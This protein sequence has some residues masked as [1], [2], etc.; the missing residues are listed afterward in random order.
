MSTSRNWRLTLLQPILPK[1]KYYQAIGTVVNAALARLLADMLAIPDI[2]K[3]E[4]H[5]LSELCH[6]LNASEG[7]FVEDPAQV[8]AM[9]LSLSSIVDVECDSLRLSSHIF[10]HGSSSTIYQSYW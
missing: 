5:N 6:I 8:S 2:I 9:T 10:L 4:S 1:S 7:L 3:D